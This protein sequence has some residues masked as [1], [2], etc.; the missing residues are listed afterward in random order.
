MLLVSITAETLWIRKRNLV[1]IAYDPKEYERNLIPTEEML[2]KLVER[3]VDILSF[4]ER[5]WS[6]NIPNPNK[7]WIKTEDNIAILRITNF[8]DWWN[9]IGKK[10]RNMVRKAQKSGLETSVVDP[11]E[12]LAEGICKIYNETPVRQGRAFSHYGRTLQNVTAE[13][14]SVNDSTFIAGYFQGEI[15]GFIQLIYGDDIAVVSQI[16][17]LQKFWD[18]AINNALVAKAVEVCAGKQVQWIMYGRMGN[19]PSLDT[20]KRSNCF[21]K[22][23]L[24]RYYIPLT[25]K[26]KLVTKLG[27]QE[28]FKDSMPEWLKKPLFPVF[29]WLSR[30]KTLAK[31]KFHK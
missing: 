26:G 27:L 22:Y 21:E 29:A 13:V 14:L 4:I 6:F 25:L 23:P 7:S 18:K 19:H 5:R 1:N 17:S 15:V 24:T 11:S 31:L 3:R 20:F 8:E 16:L 30:T 10:T 28:D 9:K 2:R 12:K